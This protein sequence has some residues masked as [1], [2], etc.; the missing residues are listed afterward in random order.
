MGKTIGIVSLKGGVGKTSVAI[1]LADSLSN[2]GKRVLLIDGNFSAP[3]I[4]LH[5]NILEPENT[6]HHV[7]RGSSN[8]S[9]AIYNTGKF[10]V[11]PG[12]IFSNNNISP[13]KFRNKIKYLK[14]S[15]DLILIDS[16]PRLDTETLA[17]M[18]ACDEILTIATPDYPTLANT[19]NAVKMAKKRKTPISGLF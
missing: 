13:M 10:H 9:N 8:I 2:L 3:N 16:S 15:Y 17:I 1:S 6:I 19:I 7:L 12:S 11:I 4:G 5:L 14:N 18:M